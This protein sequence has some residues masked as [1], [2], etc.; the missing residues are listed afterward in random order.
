[1]LSGPICSLILNVGNAHVKGVELEG[2]YEAGN[3]FMLDSALS[4]IDF[5]IKDVSALAQGGAIAPGSTAPYTPKWKWSAGAQYTL[6]LGGSQ[7]ITPRVD[8]SYTDKQYTNTNNLER[9][10]IDS[11]SITNA[12]LT[13]R[14]DEHNLEAALEV[15]N[16]FDKYYYTT[17]YDAYDRAG[18]I[19][20]S[21][22]H[23]REWAV[24]LK[25]K[26]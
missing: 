9:S 6:Q 14:N 4:Y 22:G 23:P 11:Y 2:S 7:S 25:K 20:G 12:R 8:F 26:F 13:W 24:T 1:M 21:P 10:A 5:K 17:I 19:S 3:G 18:I 15:T 16:I